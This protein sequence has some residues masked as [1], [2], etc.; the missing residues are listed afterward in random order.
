MKFSPHSLA[1]LAAL[2]M[3]ACGS[4]PPVPDW[5]L[6]AHGAAQRAQQAWLSGDDKVAGSE[7]ARARAEVARTARP[8]LMARL[9]LM[10]CAAEVASLQTGPCTAFDALRQDAGDQDLAYADY[11]AG[12]LDPARVALLPEAQRAAA[13]NV[14]AIAAIADPLSRLVAAGAALRAGRA[15]PETLVLA[16]DTASAQGWRRPVLAWLLLREQR[17]RTGGDEALADALQR[18]IALVQAGGAAAK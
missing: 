3:A 16:T 2:L 4:A 9:E 8:E 17:A 11:L 1:M 14:A 10:R 18:R 7:W 12:Q 5:Q 6:N 15:T 13:G